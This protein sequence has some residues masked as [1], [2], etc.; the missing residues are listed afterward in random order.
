M[1]GTGERDRMEMR[2]K[3]EKPLTPGSCRVLQPSSLRLV[4]ACIWGKMLADGER[5]AQI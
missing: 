2:Q 1:G 3:G 5:I 4:C